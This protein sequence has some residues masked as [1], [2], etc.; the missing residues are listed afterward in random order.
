[1]REVGIFWSP[2][3]FCTRREVREEGRGGRGCLNSES[4]LV[5]TW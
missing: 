5:L 1:M 2:S 4:V 3:R